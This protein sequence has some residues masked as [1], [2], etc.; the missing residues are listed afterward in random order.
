[1]SKASE[2]IQQIKTEQVGQTGKKVLLV[3]GTD[4][5]D[6][7]QIFLNKK[8]P[9]WEQTWTVAHMGNKKSVLSGLALEPDWVGLVDRD[10]W[11]AEEQ[12]SYKSQYQNLQVLP[13]FCLE[14]YLVNPAELWQAFPAKQQAKVAG[15]EEEF[16]STLLESLSDWIRHAALWHGVRP[17]WRQLRAAGFPDDVTRFPPLT[18][19]E[20]LRK[21]FGKWHKL[22]DAENLLDRVH[23]IEAKLS[24]V[25]VDEVCQNWLHAKEFYT[26]V[27][28]EVLNHLLGVKSVKER[29]LAIFR[30]RSV[31]SDLDGVW[32]AMELKA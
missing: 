11:T 15:G 9:G 31:P 16:R 18:D 29:R 7:Y 22:L 21:F 2:R 4:D 28:H 25:D 10:E 3:E 12:V 17:L 32:Q 6:A 5:K 19:D 30:T 23:E 14:S 27:V 1:M 13:R 20:E 24:Q 8:F 26:K